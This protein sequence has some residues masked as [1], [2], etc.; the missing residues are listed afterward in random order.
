MFLLRSATGCENYDT[1]AVIHFLIS[2]SNE[3]S[4]PDSIRKIKR[5]AAA[6][7]DEADSIAHTRELNW[8]KKIPRGESDENW[9]KHISIGEVLRGCVVDE[10]IMNFY[11]NE[12]TW[13]YWYLSLTFLKWSWLQVVFDIL[14]NSFLST[15]E[16]KNILIQERWSYVSCAVGYQMMHQKRKKIVIPSMSFLCSKFASFSHWVCW[17]G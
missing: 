11:V 2:I 12:A 15:D 1:S 5:D 10:L 13:E 14:L 7:W 9:K 4:N 3:W 6:A 8:L 17:F 16:A